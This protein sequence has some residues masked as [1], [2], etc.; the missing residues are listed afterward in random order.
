MFL[1]KKK[2]VGLDMDAF[3]AR[4]VELTGN[5]KTPQLVA[6]GRIPLEE[7]TVKEG[8]VIDSKKAGEALLQL[9]EEADIVREEVILGVSNPGVLVR[10]A[11]FPRVPQDKL[12][13]LIRFQAQEFLPMPLESVVLDHMVVGEVREENKEMLEVLLVAARKETVNAFVEALDSARLAPQEIDVSSLALLR[14][15]PPEDKEKTVALVHMP[16]EMGNVLIAAKGVPRLARLIP[17]NLINFVGKEILRGIGSCSDL[18]T[19]DWSEYN[20]YEWNEAL[21]NEIRS[22]ID[23]YHAYGET[24]RVEKI[25]LSGCGSRIPGVAELLQETLDI[26]VENSDPLKGIKISSQLEEDLQGRATD[27]MINI[28]LALRGLEE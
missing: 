6:C 27:F 4:V 1:F 28:S 23:Y 16:Y 25:C 3:E 12:G 2:S 19:L 9:W 7:G 13:N 20:I 10:F 22:S 17:L 5:S 15:I 14:M 18:E 11:N 24:T 21:V 8:S 26:P